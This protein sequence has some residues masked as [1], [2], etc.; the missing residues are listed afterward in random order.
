ML[1]GGYMLLA[2]LTVKKLLER[3]AKVSSKRQI[4]KILELKE[5]EKVINHM[6]N[7]KVTIIP[8]ID[9]SELAKKND[10]AS[11]KSHFDKLDTGK[12]EITHVDL[13]N[14]EEYDVVKKLYFIRWLES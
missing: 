11:L 10:L 8:V 9:T 1:C 12:L 6:S 3:F 4:K 2:I 7:G 13:S 5:E 14:V